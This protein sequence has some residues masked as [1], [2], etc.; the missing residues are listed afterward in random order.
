MYFIT[1]LWTTAT[2]YTS[3]IISSKDFFFLLWGKI[4][5]FSLVDGSRIISV[6]TLFNFDKKTLL[7]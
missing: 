3:I 1:I 7:M 2:N 4:F 5:Q 6:N